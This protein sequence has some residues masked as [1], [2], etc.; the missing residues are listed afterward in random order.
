MQGDLC[1]EQVFTADTSHRLGAKGADAGGLKRRSCDDTG[2]PTSD[3][4]D[5]CS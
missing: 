2:M 4:L 3:S 1:R 5:S